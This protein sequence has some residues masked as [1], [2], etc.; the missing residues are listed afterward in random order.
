M[1]KRKWPLKEVLAWIALF[2]FLLYLFLMLTGILKSPLIAD[3]IG[4][5]SLGYF[6]GIQVQKLNYVVKE[7]HTVKHELKEHMTKKDAHQ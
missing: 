7:L 1:P 6:L 2:I 5:L 4:V 3:L